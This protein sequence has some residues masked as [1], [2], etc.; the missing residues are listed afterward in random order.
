M[1]T[2][3]NS[4]WL[5]FGNVTSR[6]GNKVFDYAS[7]LVITSLYPAN[8]LMMGIYQSVETVVGL[9]FNLHAGVIAD[10]KKRKNILLVTDAVS[11]GVCLLGLFLNFKAY[12][13]IF[14]LSLN[15][16]LAI[17]STFSAPAY[18]AIVKE[19]IAKD[20]TEVHVAHF[21]LYKEIFSIVAPSLGILVWKIGGLKFAFFFNFLTFLASIIASLSLKVAETSQHEVKKVAFFKE[22]KAGIKYTWN[23]KIIWQTIL[24][25][26]GVNFFLAAYN[27]LLPYLNHLYQGQ[28]S[29]AYGKALIGE[30]IG[31]ILFSFLD[32][33]F[34]FKQGRLKII[35]SLYGLGV[36]LVL[37]PVL[38][39]IMPLNLAWSI[40]L[41]F[42]LVGGFLALFNI[43]FY[44]YIQ[45]IC[46]NK[47]LGRVFSVIFTVAILFM[48]LGSFIFGQV[49]SINNLSCFVV[50]G[51]G[52]FILNT[53]YAWLHK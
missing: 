34:K 28:I 19:A 20:Y 44:T 39:E 23:H 38:G 30:S 7:Q 43:S 17:C 13:Y 52:I 1:K 41:P 6:V 5:I 46:D 31:S 18:N 27:L 12:M 10:M 53:G 22:I 35:I 8:P 2:K 24:L 26:S 3:H 16:I 40:Y 51:V 49:M 4:F 47:Y 36:G 33:K 45:Y 15:I 11:A 29:N 21:N 50:A 37:L 25:A 14:L 32:N 9:I 48:P 42:I